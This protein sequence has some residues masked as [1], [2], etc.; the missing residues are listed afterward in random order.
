MHKQAS[1]LCSEDEFRSNDA[2]ESFKN[3][4][5]AIPEHAPN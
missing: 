2:N 3:F 5:I 4:I 1:L